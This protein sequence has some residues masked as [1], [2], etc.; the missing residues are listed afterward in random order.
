[1]PF[2]PRGKPNMTAWLGAKCDPEQYGR[3]VLFTLPKSKL[4]PGPMQVESL[5]SQNPTISQTTTLWGQVSEV[6]R[7][8]LVSI[9]IKNSI[10]YVEPLYIQAAQVKIPELKRVLMYYGGS[11][12]MGTSIEDALEQ[13]FGE[14][15]PVEPGGPTDVA[16]L[17]AEAARLWREAQT[18]VQSGDWAG[19]GRAVKELGKVLEELEIL[20]GVRIEDVPIM[21]ESPIQ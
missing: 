14:G 8:N 6:I 18:L 12:V 15:E 4:V 13:L 1:M 5:F 16:G 9:P 10:L 2:T 7:G 21:P 20:T 3:M 19:Y 17:V 11:V